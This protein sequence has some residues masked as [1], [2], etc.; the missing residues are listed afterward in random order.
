MAINLSKA[1]ISLNEFQ[2]LSTGE[3]NAGDVKFA[4][5]TK[6]GVQPSAVG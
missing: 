4:G 5:E 1:N 3:C 6:L 2:R